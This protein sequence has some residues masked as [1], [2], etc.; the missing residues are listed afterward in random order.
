VNITHQIKEKTLD[1][2]NLISGS[3]RSMRGDPQAWEASIR[4]FEDRDHIQPAPPG[5]ILFTGSSSITFWSS[6]ERDMA[7]LPVLNRGFGGSRIGDVVHYAGRII[8]PYHPRAI[9][10]YAGT[11]D[12]AGPRP[13][14]PGQVFEE[15]TRFVERVH[16]VLPEVPI[17]YVS[18]CPAPSR[19]NYWPLIREANRL[20]QVHAQTNASLRFIDITG[21][22]LA[23]DGCPDRRLFRYDRLH[24]NAR[25]YEK[26][27]ALIKP[28]LLADL[29]S[30]A[31]DQGWSVL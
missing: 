29:F 23:P 14:T 18:I 3:L 31:P 13:A 27:T 20:I 28:V 16:A 2:Y 8:L 30:T 10:L 9:V 15:Y 11:N 6:L 25:G 26:W 21:A 12:I 4:R 7:P 5:V 24:P 1:T 19:W 17:Y 22:F